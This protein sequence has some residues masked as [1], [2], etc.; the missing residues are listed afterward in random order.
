M[1]RHLWDRQGSQLKTNRREVPRFSTW[2]RRMRRIIIIFTP[3]TSILQLTRFDLDFADA[4]NPMSLKITEQVNP[5]NICQLP[6]KIRIV[7][8][9]GNNPPPWWWI[10]KTN[11]VGELKKMLN[12]IR[13]WSPKS[14]SASKADS[15]I[16]C[17]LPAAIA[18]RMQTNYHA[19]QPGP[20]G[21]RHRLVAKIKAEIAAGTYD[22]E[23]KWLAAEAKLLSR[24]E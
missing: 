9:H 5:W 8:L 2:S 10:V 16:E 17:N 6:C 24:F 14:K 20:D 15:G 3:A 11:A 23:E 21:I 22:T 18:E 19:D 12:R 4:Y 7:T 1:T 13:N